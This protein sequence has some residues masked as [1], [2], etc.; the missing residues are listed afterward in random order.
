MPAVQP[1]LYR[2]NNESPRTSGSNGTR[3]QEVGAARQTAAAAVR[4][5]RIQTEYA[6]AHVRPTLEFDLDKLISQ[7]F[8]DHGVRFKVHESGVIF[9]RIINNQ[10]DEIVR[11]FPA[12][13]ILDIVH[14]MAQRLGAIT[15]KRI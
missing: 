8:P 13:N 1:N 11:E 14:S 3:V 15:N 4:S 7:M 6:E 12:E 5:T 2:Q 9:T 10:T